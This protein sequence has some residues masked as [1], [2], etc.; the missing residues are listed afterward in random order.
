MRSFSF[1]LSLLRSINVHFR[2]GFKKD[3]MKSPKALN[4]IDGHEKALF[5]PTVF[6]LTYG[7]WEIYEDHRDPKGME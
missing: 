4:L 7:P 2:L 5:L 1:L 3:C 6:T